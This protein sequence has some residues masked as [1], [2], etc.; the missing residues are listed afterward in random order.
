MQR[1]P[2]SVRLPV[3]TRRPLQDSSRTHLPR[4]SRRSPLQLVHLMPD[5]LSAQVPPPLP[6][7]P[8]LRGHAKAVGWAG[9]GG[10]MVGSEV[11]GEPVGL[12]VGTSVGQL[13]HATGHAPA[14]CAHR[15][16]RLSAVMVLQ[17]LSGSTLPLQA[18]TTVSAGTDVG[19]AVGAEVIGDELVG[20]GVGARVQPPQVKGQRS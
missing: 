7:W 19:V 20:V 5:D 15:M 18:A 6:A 12:G 13:S 10:V 14:K 11:A 9:V 4:T 3:W 17:G 2:W 16:F 8:Q 1:Q